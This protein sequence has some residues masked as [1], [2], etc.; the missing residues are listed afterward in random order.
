MPNRTT[1][2]IAARLTSRSD[3]GYS[4]ETVVVIALLAA[5]ALGALAVIGEAVMDR[6]ESITLE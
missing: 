6:A 3:A 2:H 5:L 1:A 4:T